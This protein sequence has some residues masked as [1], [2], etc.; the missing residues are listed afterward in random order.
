MAK[1]Q[2]KGGWKT[3][4]DEQFN[5]SYMAELRLFLKEEINLGKIIYPPMIKVFNHHKLPWF[6]L[7]CHAV[8]G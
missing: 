7:A 8:C 4:L 1:H 5:S 2:I 6:I 3:E